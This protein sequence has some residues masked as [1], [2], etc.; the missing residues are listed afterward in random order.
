MIGDA[1]QRS[2]E[3]TLDALYV[4]KMTWKCIDR[5]WVELQQRKTNAERTKFPNSWPIE[6]S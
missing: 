6:Q 3:P 1:R 5:P 4:G 2:G